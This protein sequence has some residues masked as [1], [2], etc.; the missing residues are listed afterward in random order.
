MLTRR[1]WWRNLQ[2]KIR[3]QYSQGPIMWSNQDEGRNGEPS[4]KEG[5][6]MQDDERINWSPK[7]RSWSFEQE[8]KYLS[9]P[10]WHLTNFLD[11]SGLIFA[12]EP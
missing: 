4:S 2:T 11:K 7:K 5:W 6:R 12:G 3:H 9:N 1:K 8:S 10:R